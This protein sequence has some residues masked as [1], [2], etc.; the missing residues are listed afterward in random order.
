MDTE[1]ENLPIRIPICEI[2]QD[3]NVIS[4]WLYILYFKNLQFSTSFLPPPISY[5]ILS[6][7]F[8][9]FCELLHMNF[10]FPTILI[11]RNYRYYFPYYS[12]NSRSLETERAANKAFDPALTSLNST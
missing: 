6:A 8:Q 12:S 2:L 5:D 1:C 3:F 9:A 7:M 10:I 4:K 11:V